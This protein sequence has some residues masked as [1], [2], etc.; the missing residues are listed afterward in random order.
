MNSRDRNGEAAAIGQAVSILGT[1]LLGNP[2]DSDTAAFI[3]GMASLDVTATWPFG[4]EQVVRQADQLIKQGSA[5]TRKSQSE[6]Y[7]RLFVGPGHLEA[8]P[9]G[10]VYL[11]SDQVVF[12]NSELAL[13]DWLRS[14]GIQRKQPLGRVG[15]VARESAATP[16]DHIG[17]MLV[18]LGWVSERRNQDLDELLSDHLLPWADRYF[19]LLQSAARHPLYQGIALLGRTTL[20]GIASARGISAR[21]ASLYF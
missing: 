21:S 5:L 13:R 10:S 17:E 12:G 3:E 7:R 2:A 18:L 14:R 20:E 16:C 9:W 6:E 4:S 19:E 11:D 1:L 8:P 15:K